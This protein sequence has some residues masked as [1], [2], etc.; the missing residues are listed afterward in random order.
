MSQK[1]RMFNKNRRCGNPLIGRKYDFLQCLT[2]VSNI[3]PFTQVYSS[4]PKKD[5]VVFTSSF[6]ILKSM[7]NIELYELDT[8]FCM[9]VISGP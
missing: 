9:K 8:T 1:V 3:Q 5:K 4:Q 7:L 2:V 6:G